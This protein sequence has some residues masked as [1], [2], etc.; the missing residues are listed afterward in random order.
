MSATE[1][2]DQH[3]DVPMFNAMVATASKLSGQP[4]GTW[5][6]QTLPD[7][8]HFCG[9]IK[10]NMLDV[11]TSL[12]ANAYYSLAETCKRAI[13]SVIGH[14]P[15]WLKYKKW[16][17]FVTDVSAY[18]P[19][20]CLT[21]PKD[22]SA[23]TII[24][25]IRPLADIYEGP[26][27]HVILKPRKE[28]ED[29][30]GR[31]APVLWLFGDKHVDRQ[32][33]DTPCDSSNH[34]LT[35]YSELPL[36]RQPRT[37]FLPA[38]DV[39]AEASGIVTDF[40]LEYWPS[41]TRIQDIHK[42]PRHKLPY[43]QYL[44]DSIAK[45]PIEEQASSI[46]DTTNSVWHCITKQKDKC[47]TKILRVHASN[48]RHIR[49]D[50]HG[51]LRIDEL[52]TFSAW[53]DKC[54]AIFGLSWLSAE[55]HETY[56]ECL[57]ILCKR[58]QLGAVTFT[59]QFVD[60]KFLCMYTKPAFELL[61]IPRELKDT[62][63]KYLVQV[64]NDVYFDNPHPTFDPFMYGNNLEHVFQS[65]LKWYNNNPSKSDSGGWYL[66]GLLGT[67]D[68]FCLSR[69]FKS[70]L[71]GFPSQLSCVYVGDMHVYNYIRYLTVIMP[72]YE[73]VQMDFANENKCLPRSNKLYIDTAV[74]YLK[75]SRGRYKLDS[76]VIF[77]SEMCYHLPYASSAQKWKDIVTKHLSWKDFY[78]NFASPKRVLKE[79]DKI[80]AM[81]RYLSEE[82]LQEMPQLVMDIA[83]RKDLVKEIIENKPKLKSEVLQNELLL[84]KNSQL[85]DEE[86]TN[87][88]DALLSHFRV[89][90][91]PRVRTNVY[92]PYVQTRRQPS[93]KA[94]EREP[95]ATDTLESKAEDYI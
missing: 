86:V 40:H 60:N 90:N 58:I 63:V 42:V 88:I 44:K 2:P 21:R 39:L 64:A 33:C 34:C 69:V 78:Y 31:P 14:E 30:L 8:D 62:M 93:R 9:Y 23:D 3:E 56:K 27:S 73:I 48:P 59:K 46:Y 17:S 85:F 74:S 5:T 18:K 36:N 20:K 28:L 66:Y 4:M 10:T 11:L 35:F 57:T 12:F 22:V 72:Y 38:L 49:N 82:K 15:E 80:K 16:V 43:K 61:Q 91:T 29:L 1:D 54:D 71:G 26:I 37:S 13:S 95:K 77:I 84:L 89:K 24:N 51:L 81:I 7:L 52:T 87:N 70:P 75:K 92:T 94:K 47:P 68:L 53:K 19:Y 6:W 83:R 55:T 67:M 32:L 76:P 41:Y 45:D 25:Y 50:F 79:D 65:I